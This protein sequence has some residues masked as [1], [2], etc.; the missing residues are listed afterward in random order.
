MSW[1]TTTNGSS[2]FANATW[3]S[4]EDEA[5]LHRCVTG[6]M[7][8]CHG[9]HGSAAEHAQQVAKTLTRLTDAALTLILYTSPVLQAPQ[10]V[11]EYAFPVCGSRRP[12]GHIQVLDALP[13]TIRMVPLAL[14]LAPICGGILQAHAD[15]AYCAQQL[16]AISPAVLTR[17]GTLSAREREVLTLVGQGYTSAEIAQKLSL[18]TKTVRT[19]RRNISLRLEVA[20]SLSLA[21][22]ALAMDLL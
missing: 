6:L 12:Y 9:D 1:S 4:L 11:G 3:S 19:H 17:L 14:H 20:P 18:S 10:V 7:T 21:R 16:A 22:V 8:S 13:T 2:R 15:R 5:Y